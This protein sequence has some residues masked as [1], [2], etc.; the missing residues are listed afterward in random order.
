M[1][2]VNGW[3][4]TQ[5]RVYLNVSFNVNWYN[6]TNGFGSLDGDYWMGNELV[7][8]LISSG[9]PYKLRMEMLYT[10]G[11]I[12]SDVR[13][14]GLALAAS[15]PGL[16]LEAKFDGLSLG[17][18]LVTRGLGLNLGLVTFG[19]GLACLA[20]SSRPRPK[21]QATTVLN[22]CCRHS[23]EVSRPPSYNGTGSKFLV[24]TL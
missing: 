11:G 24:S 22:C 12:G 20:S 7:Y 21:P 23:V 2:M 6:Y 10:T 16:G 4:I 13:P 17:L 14:R 19:L 18:G 3:I 5:Q 15:R 8:Q 1:M 9:V